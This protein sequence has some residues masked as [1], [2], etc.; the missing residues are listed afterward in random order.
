MRDLEDIGKML[1][2]SGRAPEL[3]SIAESPE[4]KRLSGMLDANAVEKA[5]KSGDMEALRGI[6][7]QVMSTEDGKA[8]ARKLGSVME[9]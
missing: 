5:A 6:L 4:G 9:K 1:Q 8:I 7:Q 3:R 2:K